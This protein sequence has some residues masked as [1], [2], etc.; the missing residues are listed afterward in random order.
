MISECDFSVH[1]ISG[2]DWTKTQS[3]PASTCRSSLARISGC[4]YAV[5]S[6]SGA[7]SCWFW[8]R[9]NTD[10]TVRQTLYS[11]YPNRSQ[12]IRAFSR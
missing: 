9:R 8:M 5:P 12:S 7:A 1:D 6:R 3:F 2:V 10:T 11:E 4:G